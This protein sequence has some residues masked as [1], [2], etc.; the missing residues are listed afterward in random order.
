MDVLVVVKRPDG[1]AGVL[2]ALDVT[3]D[4]H[5]MTTVPDRQGPTASGPDLIRQTVR[6]QQV[7]CMF[8]GPT[9][10]VPRIAV[11]K[12]GE[13]VIVMI[14]HGYGD[15][16]DTVCEQLLRQGV[17]SDAALLRVE[18]DGR[19]FQ[20]L[21]GSLMQGVIGPGRRGVFVIAFDVFAVMPGSEAARIA[22]QPGA[23]GVAVAMEPARS[24][25]CH[26][27]GEC[28]GARATGKV[29]SRRARVKIVMKKIVMKSCVAHKIVALCAAL[30]VMRESLCKSRVCRE[31]CVCVKSCVV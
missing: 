15:D 28:I 17:G 27:A 7:R 23:V 1:R 30:W 6:A 8:L 18:V 29:K 4:V 22:R 20:A 31:S 10:P 14:V 2:M 24:Q 12:T 11:G 3:E 21:A 13:N 9:D 5:L 26:E 16:L 25:L 19:F